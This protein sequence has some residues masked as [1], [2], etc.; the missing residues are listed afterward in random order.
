MDENWDRRPPKVVA[1]TLPFFARAATVVGET[2]HEL[3]QMATAL[4]RRAEPLGADSAERLV[5]EVMASGIREL[6]RRLEQTEGDL[7]AYLPAP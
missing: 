3:D 2:W 4:D 5:I 7:A 1:T 6:A